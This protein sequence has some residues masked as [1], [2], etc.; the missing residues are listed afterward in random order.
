MRRS[1]AIQNIQSMY[2]GQNQP[3]TRIMYQKTA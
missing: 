2:Q 1:T 3:E